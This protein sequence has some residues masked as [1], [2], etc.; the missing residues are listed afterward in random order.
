V[1][2]TRYHTIDLHR[3][4]WNESFSLPWHRGDQVLISA[5]GQRDWLLPVI[6]RVLSLSPGTGFTL[7]GDFS[8]AGLDIPVLPLCPG[9]GQATG[10]SRYSS[11]LF[12]TSDEEHPRHRDALHFLCHQLSFDHAFVCGPHYYVVDI[13]RHT[14]TPRAGGRSFT[15]YFWVEPQTWSY[16]YRSARDCPGDGVALEIGSYVGGTTLALA[17]GCRDGGRGRVVAVDRCFGEAFAANLGAA[18]LADMVV[19]LAASSQEAAVDW[20]GWARQNGLSP[21]VRLLLLDGDHSYEAVV[22]DLELWSP[23]VDEDGVLVVHDYYN[24]FEPGVARACSQLL[25]AGSPWRIVERLADAI[26]CSRR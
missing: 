3:C 22:Q 12:I 18:D 10:R 8:L 19:P 26:A 14:R 6:E 25:A 24:P 9:Y 7:L 1:R 15:T 11:L 13:T 5:M 20:P 21:R 17:Q 2:P 23:F 4:L 16:L